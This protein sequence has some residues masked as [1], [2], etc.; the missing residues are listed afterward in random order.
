MLYNMNKQ[1]I[2]CAIFAPPARYEFNVIAGVE[3]ALKIVCSSML[4]G[5]NFPRNIDA[6]KILAIKF[7][8]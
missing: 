3:M 2:F 1:T 8:V 6:V 4:E 5:I 7:C